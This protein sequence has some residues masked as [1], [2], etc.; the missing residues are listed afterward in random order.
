MEGLLQ[1]THL[2]FI[3]LIVLILFGPGKLPE[4]GKGLGKG[5]R[6]FKDA[7]RG[8]NSERKTAVGVSL[9]PA[10]VTVPVNGTQQFT[11]TVSGSDTAVTWSVNGVPAG[12]STVGLI[13]SSGL[14]SAPGAVPMP[15]SVTIAATSQ[16][17]S[18]QSASAEVTISV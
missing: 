12:N 5:I 14:Y 16:A 10:S 2:F 11:A 13:S 15:S 17:D 1:P 6:E 18:S 7:F 9:A 8:G 3:L 4:L